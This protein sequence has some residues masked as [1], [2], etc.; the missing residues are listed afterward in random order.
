MYFASRVQAGRMLASQMLA[1]YRYENCIVLALSD[2]GAMVGA[3][4][5]MALHCPM[6]LLITEEIEL[7][8]E[9]DALGG[10]A[11]DGSFTFNSFYSPGVI[12][13]FVSE[14][15]QYIEQ[16]KMIKLQKMH[17]QIGEKITL[18]KSLLKG[19]NVIIVS[20]GMKSG[21]TLDI[22][23]Q[24][25]KPIN[26]ENMIIA[27]PIASVKAVDHMHVA[28]D[29]LYVLSVVDDYISTEHYYD[30]EDVPD[31]QTVVDT[32]AKIIL[33]WH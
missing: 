18:R 2:G 5:A 9:P 23:A 13:E 27:S 4:I 22:A 25:L 21:F 26:T 24:F 3:Q 7:P 8:R 12:D 19:R 29:E 30:K 17:R 14:Y 15:F 11:E 16:E 20:D 33:K 32:I 1:K 10:I 28:A 6:E 31:H